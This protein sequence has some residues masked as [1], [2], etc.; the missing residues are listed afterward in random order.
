[1][2]ARSVPAMVLL[3]RRFR[4]D[5]RGVAAIEFAMLALPLFMAIFIILECAIQ[6]FVWTS[7]DLAVQRT[8]RQ[9]RTG[10][11]QKQSL[12]AAEFKSAVCQQISNIFG[13]PSRLMLKV[14]V[15]KNI[16]SAVT[17]DPITGA[18]A[19]QVQETYD[20]GKSGD[21]LLVQAFFRWPAFTQLV[22]TGGRK[23]NAGDYVLQST[24][25]FRNE[26]F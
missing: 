4:R 14:D 10:E 17:H 12:D 13:C 18:G 25:L 21:I 11:V 6:Y 19:L 24:T 5:R 26:P 16:K 15:L 2:R 1:M 20:I 22:T 7:V 9:V 8:A 3:A 23:T